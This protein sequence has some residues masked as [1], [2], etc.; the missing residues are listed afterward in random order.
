MPDGSAAVVS[1][2]EAGP[3]LEAESVTLDEAVDLAA[4]EDTESRPPVEPRGALLAEALEAAAQ[5]LEAQGMSAA[6]AYREAIRSSG[7]LSS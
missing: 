1:F 7:V 4:D 3:V 2:S 5:E 6:A